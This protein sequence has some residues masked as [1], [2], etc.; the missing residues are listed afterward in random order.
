M[1]DEEER[2]IDEVANS[3]D[4]MLRWFAVWHAEQY[5]VD[6]NGQR[7]YLRPSMPALFQDNGL[8]LVQDRPDRSPQRVG[9]EGHIT[10]VNA[11]MV[12]MTDVTIPAP[13]HIREWVSEIFS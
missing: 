13:D 1:S 2:I 9:T 8:M 12:K 6:V 3:V 11:V 5:P 7:M 10:C 4:P